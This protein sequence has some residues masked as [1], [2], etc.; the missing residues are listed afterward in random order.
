MPSTLLLTKSPLLSC[1]ALALHYH[2]A[3][4][5]PTSKS[6]R[7]LYSQPDSG[8]DM[9]HFRWQASMEEREPN[10]KKGKLKTAHITYSYRLHPG[11]IKQRG[12]EQYT[13]HLTTPQPISSPSPLTCASSPFHKSR[14]QCFYTRNT[15]GKRS[16]QCRYLRLH[17]FRGPVQTGPIASISDSS[18]GPTEVINVATNCTS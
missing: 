1:Q 12:H 13:P 7:E 5:L 8:S 3:L 11:N 15:K 4:Q 10:N 16:L 18:A 6:Q 2:Q 14:W 9:L 17:L